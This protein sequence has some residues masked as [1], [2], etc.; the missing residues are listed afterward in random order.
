MKRSLVLCT[1]ISY[2]IMVVIVELVEQRTS[3]LF[4]VIPVLSVTYF[5]VTIGF[6]FGLEQRTPCA[7]IS[8]R[9][10]QESDD[11][12]E[13]SLTDQSERAIRAPRQS[14]ADEPQS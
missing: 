3:Y 8:T 12:V 1:I 2:H 9:C 10:S 11:G 7:H 5:N 13:L 6:F 14:P 4:G